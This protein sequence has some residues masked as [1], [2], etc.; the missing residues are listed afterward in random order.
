MPKTGM[1][2]KDAIFFARMA[3]KKRSDRLTEALSSMFCEHFLSIFHSRSVS[4]RTFINFQ[5]KSNELQQ[6]IDGEWSGAGIRTG[7]ALCIQQL[8]GIVIAHH[9]PYVFCTLSQWN[10]F[11]LKLMTL[12]LTHFLIDFK[13]DF[14][15]KTLSIGKFGVDGGEK[16]LPMKNDALILF[17]KT[18]CYIR[19]KSLNFLVNKHIILSIRQ[20]ILLTH[21][22][23]TIRHFVCWQLVI[24]S[25]PNSIYSVG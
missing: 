1:R 2:V 8:I 16:W 5:V 10:N 14:E 4:A 3:K 19:G 17:I 22:K 9:T 11:L 12:L 15:L 20:T 21:E 7:M 6:N 18:F 13:L 25:V 23:T 24:N